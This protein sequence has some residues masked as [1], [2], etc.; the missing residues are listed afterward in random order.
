MNNKVAR[1]KEIFT[2]LNEEKIPYCVLRNYDFLLKQRGPSA[3]SER[4]VDLCVSKKDFPRFASLLTSRGF[5]TRKPSFSRKHVAFFHIKNGEK[6]SFDVQVGGIYWNDMLYLGEKDLFHNR[7]M[8]ANFYVPSKND[9][10]V[11][12]LLHSILGKRYFKKEY[13]MILTELVGKV[14]LKYVHKKISCTLPT[15]VS[16]FLIGCVRKGD[17]KK[18]LEKKYTLI[19]LFI[20]RSVRRVLI[21]LRLF[22]RWAAWKRFLVPFPLIS[23]I[24][25]DGAGK[26]S[27][28][29]S[30]AEYLRK[31][32]R[33]VEVVYMGRGRDHILPITKIGYL[34][35]KKEK[36]ALTSSKK[37]G[38]ASK[39]KSLFALRPFLYSIVAPLF[40]FDQFLR[41][42]IYIFP[43]RMRGKIVVTDRYC[44]DLLLMNLVPFW[45]KRLL[46][47][48]FPAP[49]VS[50]YLY[51]DPLTL[52]RRRPE[53]SVRELS[54]QLALFKRMRKLIRFVAIKTEDKEKDTLQAIDL[55]TSKL[56]RN[57]Y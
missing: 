39:K 5:L 20:F 11:M 32:N 26:S 14:D 47:I 30:L 38:S 4:S 40:A 28:V 13:A 25:P 33:A 8:K 46:L 51:N 50:I 36:K 22:V 57:W 44:S 41:Y 43:L 52:H 10:F 19:L 35:K 42:W 56:V 54:R 27:L 55:V 7:I 16:S 6:I 3:K 12:L 48:P 21:S 2:L 24:G 1:L 17:F 15:A 45:L 23:V 18:I 31:E 37:A 53:E 34:Y 9:T 29:A 49:M